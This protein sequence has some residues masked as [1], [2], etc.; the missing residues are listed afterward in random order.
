MALRMATPPRAFALATAAALGIAGCW[1]GALDRKDGAIKIVLVGMPDNA[2]IVDATVTGGEQRSFHARVPRPVD[3]IVAVFSAVPVGR[4][5]VDVKLFDE[6]ALTPIEEMSEMVDVIEHDVREVI[7]R[8]SKAP[9]GALDVRI[10]HPEDGSQYEIANGP[11]TLQVMKG[12]P[13]IAIDLRVTVNDRELM[14]SESVLDWTADVDPHLAGDVVPAQLAIV[15]HACRAGSTSLCADV[16]STIE[17]NRRHWSA[18]LGGAILAPVAVAGDAVIAASRAGDVGAFGLAE[19]TS[20]KGAALPAA[21]VAGPIVMDD[22]AI[23]VD[24]AG[25]VHALPLDLAPERWSLALG[26]GHAT[27]P[28]AQPERARIVVGS[29]RQVFAIDLQAHAKAELFRLADDLGAPPYVDPLGVVAADVR[30]DLSAFDSMDR[31]VFDASAGAPVYAP[32]VRGLASEII[33]VTSDGVVNRYDAD[34]GAVIGAPIDLAAAVR[35]APIIAGDHLVIAAADQLAWI[36]RSGSV[37]AKYPVGAPITAAPRLVPWSLKPTVAIGLRTGAV[38][39]ARIDE[40]L[41]SLSNI[42]GAVLALAPA[43]AGS[44]HL[45]IAG[46]SRGDLEA[47]RPEEGFFR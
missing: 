37:V 38:L 27:G 14:L 4:D 22:L 17:V 30:G 45:V 36:D 21:P 42:E 10:E 11:I 24:A 2:R 5:R 20:P 31:R 35:A 19:G 40:P 23:V 26:V 25:T 7:V 18:K 47:L 13:M 16:T 44:V 32:I 1:G 28:S 15:A 8:F 6:E 3:G 12:D 29:G 33:A 41:K 43:D 9:D 34:S 39:F 46:G